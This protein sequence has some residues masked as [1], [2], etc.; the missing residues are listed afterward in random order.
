ML[1]Y[2]FTLL[3]SFSSEAFLIQAY[4]LAQMLNIGTVNNARIRQG[5]FAALGQR[6]ISALEV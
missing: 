6:S 2:Y 4:I 3:S 5:C 1:R